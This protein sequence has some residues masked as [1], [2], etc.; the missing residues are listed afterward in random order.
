MF[1]VAE[2]KKIPQAPKTLTDFLE[3]VVSDKQVYA[4]VLGTVH[5]GGDTANGHTV[6][7]F[8]LGHAHH[9]HRHLASDEFHAAVHGLL[10]EFLQLVDVFLPVRRTKTK[11]TQISISKRILSGRG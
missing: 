1:H 8:L 10:T 9:V 11:T 3:V 6:N 4:S 2:I 5:V 7:E